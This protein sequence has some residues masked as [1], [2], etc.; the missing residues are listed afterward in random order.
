MKQLWM[1]VMMVGL[2]PALLAAGPAPAPCD[3]C[4]PCTGGCDGSNGCGSFKERFLRWLG[5]RPRYCGSCT[6][7]CDRP[8]P[9]LYTFFPPCAEWPQPPHFRCCTSPCCRR[10][11]H[12]GGLL[13]RVRCGKGCRTECQADCQQAK[14]ADEKKPAAVIAKPATTVATAPRPQAARVVKPAPRVARV[15]KPAPQVIRVLKPVV[16]PEEVRPV[17]VPELEPPARWLPRFR[18]RCEPAVEP[19]TEPRARWFPRIRRWFGSEEE[20]AVPGEFPHAP[21]APYARP[22]DR[23]WL[24]WLR[25][26]DDRLD[27]AMEAS[28]LHPESYWGSVYRSG[29]RMF[30]LPTG[31]G[32]PGAS[33]Y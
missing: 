19:A 31:H 14:G 32:V 11:V 33:D 2:V 9:P 7:H 4:A 16:R 5:Y 6:W 29:H 26:G 30:A 8:T 18:K 28:Q 23:P 25:G 15:V 1:G 3:S 13:D 22:Y 24:G 12:V 21:K 17:V 10:D 20:S 27:Q